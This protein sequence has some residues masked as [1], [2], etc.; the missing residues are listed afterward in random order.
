M[1]T[2]ATDLIAPRTDGAAGPSSRLQAQAGG[3][4][5]SGSAR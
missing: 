2:A 3:E 1:T 5:P 4:R